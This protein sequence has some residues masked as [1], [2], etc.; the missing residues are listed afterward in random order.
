MPIRRSWCSASSWRPRT[1]CSSAATVPGPPAAPGGIK[2]IDAETARTAGCDHLFLLGLGE[3]Q[4]PAPPPKGDAAGGD[5]ADDADAHAR[6]EMLL[7]FGV[8]TRPV[9]TLTLS[10]PTLDNQ[11]R[12]LFPGP[13]VRAVTDLFA[14]NTVR[15]VVADDLDPVPKLAEAQTADDARVAA[16]RALLDGGDAAP[17]ATLLDSPADGPAVR[18]ALGAVRMIAARG[19]TPGV[20]EF[21]GALSDRNRAAWRRRRPAGHEFSASELEAFAQN[22]HRYFLNRVLGAERPEPPRL[23]G[24]RAAR[25]GAMHEALKRTHEA[26][27]PG[28]DGEALAERMRE[29]LRDLRP[30]N[31]TFARWHDGLWESERAVLL[32]FADRYAEQVRKDAAKVRKGHGCDP[33]PTH[34]E[35]A[36]GE[37]TPDEPGE[38]DP[39]RLPAA[40]FGDGPDATRVTGR[41]DRLDRIDA[42]DGPRYRVVD[43]KT[44][45]V[46]TFSADD[47]TAGL[48]LQLAVYA[49]AARRL[50]LVDEA[51]EI[52]DLVYWKVADDGAKSGLKRGTKLEDLVGD[53]PRLLDETVPRLAA[54]VRGGVFPVNPEEVGGPAWQA[55]F[56]RVS[57]T[58]EVRA[59]ADRLHK[60]PPPWLAPPAAEPDA[61]VARG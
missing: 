10:Y 61:G 50:G 5:D 7:F 3:G 49:E 53:L 16:A 19:R 43:Y 47:V 1:K 4:F 37:R 59:V 28:D 40:V 46:S 38:E 21:D 9:K 42:A 57:R 12:R 33:R 2:C 6:A 30:R 35:V 44:G 32:D 52:A 39:D 60:W 15:R 45:G 41:I 58:A 55:A 11:A 56:A 13:F 26:A 8:V 36:F 18:S 25:G 17:L 14:G 23:A 48:R 51:A 27:E 54:A 22:P 31:A 34:L 20:T 24:D 29:F